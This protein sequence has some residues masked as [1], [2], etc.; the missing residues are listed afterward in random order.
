MAGATAFLDAHSALAI[1]PPDELL[2]EAAKGGLSV[3]SGRQTQR[4]SEKVQIARLLQSGRAF[5]W[6]VQ[7]VRQQNDKAYVRWPQALLSKGFDSCPTESF[8]P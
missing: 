4:I 2:T 1:L 5:T 3:L 7:A 6:K 8:E